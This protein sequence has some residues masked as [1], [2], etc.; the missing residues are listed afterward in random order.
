MTF[1][2]CAANVLAQLRLAID[3]LSQSY[4]IVSPFCFHYCCFPPKRETEQRCAVHET[5]TPNYIAACSCGGELHLCSFFYSI[6]HWYNVLNFE[7][8]LKPLEILFCFTEVST[9]RK[10][11]FLYLMCVSVEIA[12]CN[13]RRDLSDRNSSQFMWKE[14]IGVWF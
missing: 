2:M 13:K 9:L 6:A 8:N 11:I 7:L 5:H 1:C 3:Y 4:N 14:L 10:L 12:S